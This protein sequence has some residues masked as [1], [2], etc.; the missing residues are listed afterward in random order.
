MNE[1]S[2]IAIFKGTSSE[3]FLYYF[4][5]T[6]NLTAEDVASINLRPEEMPIALLRGDIDAY[7]VWEPFAY[8][9]ANLLG[10]K[11][12]VFSNNKIY[13]QTFNVVVNTDFALKNPNTLKKFL[14]A[15][16]KAEDFTRK[17][18]EES[19]KLVAE[20]LGMDYQVLNKVW[21]DYDFSI[22]L[23]RSLISNLEKDAKWALDSKIFQNTKI[24]DY[25]AMIYERPLKEIDPS[26]VNI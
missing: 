12:L 6:N 5:K 13:P 18:R 16:I 20:S 9:G 14:K 15:L 17:N 22:S 26:A 21:N 4:L 10:N 8:N 3:I 1:T 25:R 19:I 23:D 24:P 11:S 2:K 7:A